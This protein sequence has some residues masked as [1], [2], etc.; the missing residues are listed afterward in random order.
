MKS[1]SIL[2][3]WVLL[4]VSACQGEPEPD[5]TSVTLD[6][7]VL[8]DVVFVPEITPPDFGPPP[9]SDDVVPEPPDVP[10]VAPEDVAEEPVDLFEPYDPGPEPEDIPVVPDVPDVPPPP[11]CLD[12]CPGSCTLGVCAIGCT[13]VAA[14]TEWATLAATPQGLAVSVLCGSEDDFLDPYVAADRVAALPGPA[15]LELSVEIGF[16]AGDIPLGPTA[17]LLRKRDLTTNKTASAAYVP[18]GKLLPAGAAFTA[19]PLTAGP[20][21]ELAAFPFGPAEGEPEAPGVPSGIQ[22]VPLGGGAPSVLPAT[23]PRDALLLPS[24][25]LLVAGEGL[26]D[27]TGDGL[28]YSATLSSDGPHARVAALEAPRDLVTD[29]DWF[30]LTAVVEGARRTLAIALPTLLGG[31]DLPSQAFDLL[32]GVPR[33]DAWLAA[34]PSSSELGRRFL[35]GAQPGPDGTAFSLLSVGVVAGKLTVVGQ[36][37]F[38]TA[39]PSLGDARAIALGSDALLR[40]EAGLLWLRPSWTPAPAMTP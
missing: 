16:T 17:F 34:P 13:N 35:V 18:L 9:G 12:P 6:A 30:V 27:L 26:F 37:A 14:P 38:A 2:L 11:P 36:A 31:T 19:G 40:G 7:I 1:R 25:G 10:D 23:R 21:G 32:D 39:N 8:G 20:S 24:A 4:T 28:F 33:L 5:V 15:T 29:G 22:L 3:S